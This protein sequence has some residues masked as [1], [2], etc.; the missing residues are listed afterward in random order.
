MAVI[1]VASIGTSGSLA[2]HHESDAT[3]GGG[4]N[5]GFSQPSASAAPLYVTAVS[6]KLP[7]FWPKVLL[8][9]FAQIDRDSFTRVE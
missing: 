5:A 4:G 1:F 7:L 3:S 9:R 2:L 8:V 6:L